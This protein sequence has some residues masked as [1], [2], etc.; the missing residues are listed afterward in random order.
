[1]HKALMHYSA[2]LIDVNWI[3]FQQQRDENHV[4][5]S[6]SMRFSAE[7]KTDT[8]DRCMAAISLSLLMSIE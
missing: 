2:H 7:Q 3:W 1:M 5:L 8:T 6:I 4:G